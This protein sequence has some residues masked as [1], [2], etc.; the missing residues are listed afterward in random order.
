M[1]IDIDSLSYDE[2]VEWNVSPPLLTK[3]KEIKRDENGK[4]KVID[5]HKK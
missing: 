1:K 5:F 4:A 3:I 2:L